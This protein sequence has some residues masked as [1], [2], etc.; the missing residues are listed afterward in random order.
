MRIPRILTRSF[1]DRAPPAATPPLAAGDG[2][3]TAE[4]ALE[5]ALG[6]GRPPRV[7]YD[8]PSFLV[9]ALH[10]VGA[11]GAAEDGQDGRRGRRGRPG[12]AGP[13]LAFLGLPRTGFYPPSFGLPSLG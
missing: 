6:D 3:V 1:G 11:A 13:L 12:R 7:V 9:P 2:T 5:A 4:A 10:T 8:P